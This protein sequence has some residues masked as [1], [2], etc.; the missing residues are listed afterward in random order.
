M[1]NSFSSSNCS[2]SEPKNGKRDKKLVAQK[3][4]FISIIEN[5]RMEIQ[6]NTM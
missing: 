5:H 1:I 2:S 3:I 6:M 4:N